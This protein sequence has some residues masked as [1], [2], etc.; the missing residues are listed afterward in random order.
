MMSDYSKFFI[1][2][3]CGNVANLVITKGGSLV[4]CGEKMAELVP[5][6]VDA[7]VEKH[8]PVVTVLGDSVNVDV[9]SILH[10][11]QD[12]HNITFVCIETENGSQCRCLK[13]GEEPKATFSIQ[14]GKPIAAYAYCNLHGLWKTDIKL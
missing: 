12:E 13:I 9:G 2:K 6:T 8:K 14:N 10:P 4:C 11:M 3:I 1:C 5:N 7:S